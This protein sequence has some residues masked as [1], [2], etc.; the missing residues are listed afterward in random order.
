M[1]EV[2]VILKPRDPLL[3]TARWSGVLLAAIIARLASGYSGLG[4]NDIAV[5]ILLETIRRL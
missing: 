2:V 1:D 5:G 3:A 4:C